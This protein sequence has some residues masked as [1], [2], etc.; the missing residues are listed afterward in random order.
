MWFEPLLCYMGGAENINSS[1]SRHMSTRKPCKS[2]AQGALPER[3]VSSV[4]DPFSSFQSV[5]QP[6]PMVSQQ[7]LS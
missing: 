4:L 7:T 6:P 3:R 2:N 5:S 1:S